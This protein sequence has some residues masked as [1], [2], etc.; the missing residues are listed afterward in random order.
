[1][2]FCCEMLLRVAR[3]PAHLFPIPAPLR[4][5]P[6]R[7]FSASTTAAYVEVLSLLGE[8]PPGGLEGPAADRARGLLSDACA[9]RLPAAMCRLG[10]WKVWGLY[11]T[12]RDVRGGAA[13]LRSAA[14]AGDA[15]AAC[16]LGRAFLS[17]TEL[18]AAERTERGCGGGGGG[19]CSGGGGGCACGGG[20]CG[21]GGCSGGGAPAVPQ[22][23]EPET[24]EAAETRAAAA[25]AVLA[26]I[27]AMR[28]QNLAARGAATP[29]AAPAPPAAAGLSPWLD[30]VDG[31]GSPLALA[32]ST[33]HAYA[34]LHRAAAAEHPGAQVLLGNL[35]L[36]G[37]APL[38]APTRDAAAAAAAEAGAAPRV[39]EAAGW[40]ELAA[41]PPAPA[42]PHPEALHNLGLLLW[43]GAPPV[44]AD[45]ARAVR[46]FERAAAAGDANALFAL[47]QLVAAGAPHAGVTRSLQ[48][49]LPLLER[50]VAAGHGGAAHFLAQ[51]WRERGG[52]SARVRHFLELAAE[53]A[54]HAE[55]LLDLAHAKLRG[56]DGFA[57]DAAAARAL[58]AR[59]A[60]APGGDEEVKI[61]ALLALG[62]M[63][64]KGLGGAVDLGG[65]ARSYEAA[66]QMGSLEAWENLADVLARGA[67]RKHTCARGTRAQRP[68]PPTPTR[69]FTARPQPQA[70][71]NL[72]A[73]KSILEMVARLRAD[74]E[75][76][77]AVSGEEEGTGAKGSM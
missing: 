58:F 55:A 71:G 25:R 11:G 56:A 57:E 51:H 30:D 7:Y 42:E 53:G 66:A 45:P 77:R 26:E 41:A 13:L 72:D 23:F 32:S 36:R 65:A 12:P 64:V 24:A 19:D 47:G 33:P 6:L 15:E 29:A 2:K 40:Y 16:F 46:C 20:G 18:A 69:A 52:A 9:S 75:K 34:W 10:R 44:V 49:A 3:R 76:S 74:F 60:D 8:A 73:A 4:S 17:L 38:P 22:P 39:E 67:Y 48:R 28:L 14:L 61:P 68:L 37:V 27:K 43:E 63:R 1:M 62:A 31:A 50:A 59:A 70:G 35:C 54:G 5:L 21:G